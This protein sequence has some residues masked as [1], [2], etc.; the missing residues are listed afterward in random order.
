M[1]ETKEMDCW[2]STADESWSQWTTQGTA[3]HFHSTFFWLLLFQPLCSKAFV[4]YFFCPFPILHYSYACQ[5]SL[6]S[7]PPFSLPFSHSSTASLPPLPSLPSPFL[8]SPLPPPPRCL[9]FVPLSF[10]FCSSH[11]LLSYSTSSFFFYFR[12]FPLPSLQFSPLS[13]K[14]LTS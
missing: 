10:P 1:S 8:S 12:P 11:H 2:I 6:L 4:L 9:C 3:Q 14:C 13:L 5:S 7:F